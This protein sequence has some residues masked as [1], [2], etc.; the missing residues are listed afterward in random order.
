MKLVGNKKSKIT[1][2]NCDLGQSFGVYKNDIEFELLEYSSSVNIA[3]GFHAGDPQTIKRALLA[4]KE[5]NVAIGGHIG[6]QDIAGFGYN[7]TN[8]SDEALESMVIYQLGALSSFAKSLGLEIEHVRP[9]GAMYKMAVEDFQFSLKLA[10]AIK[11]FDPW[12]IYFGAAGQALQNVADEL[13]IRVA[14][15]L[16]LDKK[17]NFDGSINFEANEIV[18]TEDSI[19]RLNLLLDEN[20]IDNIEGGKTEVKFDTIHFGSKA[21]NAIELIKKATEIVTP[22]SVNYNQVE[23]SDWE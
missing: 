19:K 4:C 10:K 2:F 7:P 23:A 5:Q 21:I 15:E 22:I 20:S 3:C 11:K 16:F 6:F 9:H 17:Y 18:S 1:D 13:N 8:L 14:H 12:L